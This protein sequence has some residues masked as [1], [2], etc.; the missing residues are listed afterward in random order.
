MWQSSA[1]VSPKRMLCE[2]LAPSCDDIEPIEVPREDVQMRWQRKNPWKQKFPG[3]DGVPT[4]PLVK[5]NKIMKI[6]VMMSTEVS[7]S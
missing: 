3:H 2:G 6:L 4:V 1:L 5:K 7:M